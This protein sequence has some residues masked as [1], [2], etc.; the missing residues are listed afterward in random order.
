MTEFIGIWMFPALFLLIAAGFPIAFSMISVSFVFGYMRF[1]DKIIPLLVGKVNEVGSNYILGAIPLFVLMG[2]LLQSSGI[3]ERLYDAVYLWTRRLPGGLAIGTIIM[4]AIFAAATGVAG[5][6]E[7]VIGLLAIP[8]MLK[9]NYDKS[10]ISGTIC[11]G[12][13]LGTVIPPSITVVVLAPIASLPVGS[14]FAGILLPGLLMAN[15]FLAYILIISVIK[16]DIAPRVTDEEEI[17]MPLM[18]KLWITLVALIPPVGLIF[19]VLGSILM[20]WATPTEAAA[21]GALGCFLLALVQRKLSFEVLRISLRQTLA[22]T[23]MIILIVLA[24]SIFSTIFYASGGMRAIEG[25]LAFYGI[26]GWGAIAAIL[27]LTFVAGFVLDLIS[28]ILIIIPV[29]MPMV[30]AYNIDPLWFAIVFLIVLQAAYL[31]PPMAPSIFYLKAIAP[32][33]IKLG[34]MYRGVIPFIF[35]QLTTVALVVAFPGL[36]TWLPGLLYGPG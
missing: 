12:G 10:L 8:A 4:S 23:A 20:G 36:A 33:S 35:L 15:L 14:L 3:A 25:I 2:V 34:H 27:L 16:P 9:H 28:V 26:S 6:T 31:T 5:A 19:L 30:L 1:G 13:S 32:P 24:G 22:V 7:T 11:S 18:L 17:E 29:A 21:S